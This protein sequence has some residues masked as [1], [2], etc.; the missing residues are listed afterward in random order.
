MSSSSTSP[1]VLRCVAAR[2]RRAVEAEEEQT[3]GTPDR[4]GRLDGSCSENRLTASYR[5]AARRLRGRY[6]DD[7][8][9]LQHSLLELARREDARREEAGRRAHLAVRALHGMVDGEAAERFAT[10]VG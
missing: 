4:S 7:P 8:V 9:R 3:P 1:A 5:S 10:L 2:V 6:A